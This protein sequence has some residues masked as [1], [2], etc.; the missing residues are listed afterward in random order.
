M[1]I[2]LTHLYSSVITFSRFNE[3]QT[4]KTKRFPNALQRIQLQIQIAFLKYLK[5]IIQKCKAD[6]YK[7]N[8]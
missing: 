4:I 3:T 8:F 1:N 5:F 2:Y 7:I 6:H